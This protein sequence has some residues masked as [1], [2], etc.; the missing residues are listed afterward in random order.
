MSTLEL[1][2]TQGF[3]TTL[4]AVIQVARLQQSKSLDKAA[5]KA[6]KKASKEA[7]KEKKRAAA[8]MQAALH[9]PGQASNGTGRQPI[10]STGHQDRK[11]DSRRSQQQHNASTSA[12]RDTDHRS[13]QSDQ[14]HEPSRRD[15]DSYADDSGR[16]SKSRRVHSPQRLSASAHHRSNGQTN[17]ADRHHRDTEGN[18]ADYRQHRHD[19]HRDETHAHNSEDAHRKAA[20]GAH[21]GSR[22]EGDARHSNRDGTQYGLSWGE[23]APEH[24][25]AQDRQAF[26][27]S[28]LWLTSCTSCI[29]LHAFV[30]QAMPS[31]LHIGCCCT[32]KQCCQMCLHA[33]LMPV[34]MSS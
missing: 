2:P 23:S 26:E 7:K 27:I 25:Q 34:D 13:R 30:T 31:L 10:D 24:M 15:H 21:R 3:Y 11:D 12:P 14:R 1:T 32:A 28:C 4:F 5:K 33:Q 20:D 17:G 29:D 6:E 8:D 22:A 9:F 18:E 19:R 16:A